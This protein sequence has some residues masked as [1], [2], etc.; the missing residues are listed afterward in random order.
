MKS[1]IFLQDIV[2]KRQFLTGNHCNPKSTKSTPSAS[3][4]KPIFDYLKKND[5][6]NAKS[7]QEIWQVIRRTTTTR[8]KKMCNQGLLVD[9]ST[10]PKDPQKVFVLAKHGK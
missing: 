1:T 4:Q 7:A 10:S 9:I 8:L 5:K 6:I 3:W 2:K